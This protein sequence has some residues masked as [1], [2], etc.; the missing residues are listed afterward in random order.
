MQTRC[1][2][3]TFFSCA[4]VRITFFSVFFYCVYDS[5]AAAESRHRLYRLLPPAID[6]YITN[7]RDRD[8]GRPKAVTICSDF[9]R[10][11]SIEIPKI[12]EVGDRS[13]GR[14]NAATTCSGFYRPPANG[15]LVEKN[16][17]DRSIDDCVNGVS[18]SIIRIWWRFD[19]GRSAEKSPVS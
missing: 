18:C 7:Q 3:C 17:R 6:R 13:I 19:S 14:P 11:Q 12:S 15:R 10:Q 8:I 5:A 2:R 16:R 4:W 1:A 9:F